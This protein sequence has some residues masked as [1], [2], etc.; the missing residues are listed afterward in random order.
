MHADRMF[1]DQGYIS[2]EL[3][4]TNSTSF[5]LRF[6]AAGYEPFVSRTIRS[7]EGHVNLDVGLKTLP[8]TRASGPSGVV[9]APDHNPLAG[10]GGDVD[11]RYEGRT[12]SGSMGMDRSWASRQRRSVHDRHDRARW[13]VYF[14]AH[15]RALRDPGRHGRCYYGRA[16]KAELEAS[17]ELKTQPWAQIEGQLFIRSKPGAGYYVSAHA[18]ICAARRTQAS[19]CR[20]SSRPTQKRHFFDKILMLDFGFERHFLDFI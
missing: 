15:G 1:V 12:A 7:S 13:P 14:P 3:D 11:R 8:T 9:R 2:A 19:A 6:T 4:A 18:A 5:K 10:P 20:T 17:H 16:T